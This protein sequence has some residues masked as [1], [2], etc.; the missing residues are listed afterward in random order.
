MAAFTEEAASFAAS[1]GVLPPASATFLNHTSSKA[2]AGICWCKDVYFDGLGLE[3]M[4]C[5]APCTNFLLCLPR[6]Q[7]FTETPCTL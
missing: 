3:K 2:G 5:S 1:W 4:R 7:A 6:P